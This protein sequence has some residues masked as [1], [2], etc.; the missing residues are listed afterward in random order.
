M[1]CGLV[2]GCYLIK[3]CVDVVDRIANS[4]NPAVKLFLSLLSCNQFGFL[5]L[6]YV[7]R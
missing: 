7:W 4:F 3:L 1:A 5:L 2:I 6:D